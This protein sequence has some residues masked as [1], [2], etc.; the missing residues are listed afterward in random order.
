[1]VEGAR[2]ESGY[3][4]KSSIVGSNPIPS[5]ITTPAIHL[6]DI[7]GCF[8]SRLSNGYPC[9]SRHLPQWLS[10]SDE[11]RAARVMGS[12]GLEIT[13]MAPKDMYSLIS[14]V[15]TVAVM[16]MTGVWALAGISR[17]FFRVSGPFIPGM[18]TS[19]RISWLNTPSADTP[20]DTVVSPDDVFSH[21]SSNTSIPSGSDHDNAFDDKGHTG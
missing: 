9:G 15:W 2:L 14:V 6:S 17:S 21:D 16:K 18:M 3:R 19:S 7:S 1:M 5:A 10:H 4:V 20:V 12:K 8:S 13:S 11:I